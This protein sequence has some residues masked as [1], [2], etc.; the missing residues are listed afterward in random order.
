MAP[1]IKMMIDK[2][3]AKIG[4][5]MKKSEKFMGK[6]VARD[7]EFGRKRARTAGSRRLRLD[8]QRSY[9]DLFGSTCQARRMDL[10][11]GGLLRPCYFCSDL[12]NSTFRLRPPS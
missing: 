2:T 1:T 3:P 4:R 5:L 10:V 11:R 6:A 8:W 7:L 12:P 9:A